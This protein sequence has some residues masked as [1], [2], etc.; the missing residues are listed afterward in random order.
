[1]YPRVT[2][3]NGKGDLGLRNGPNAKDDGAR[4]SGWTIPKVTGDM[5]GTLTAT[6][7]GC[8]DAPSAPLSMLGERG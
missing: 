5:V 8:V 7:T 1:M 6:A 2:K 3:K 4:S